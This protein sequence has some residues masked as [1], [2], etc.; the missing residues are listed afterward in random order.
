MPPTWNNQLVVTG[1]PGV[2]T[3]YAND[4][5]I[6]DWTL[7]RNYAFASTDKPSSATSFLANGCRSAPAQ[8]LL[9]W[10]ER[11]SSPSSRPKRCLPS[12]MAPP[13]RRPGRHAAH[14]PADDPAVLSRGLSAP[15]GLG[16]H[17][18]DPAGEP[19]RHMPGIGRPDQHL[20]AAGR[21]DHQALTGHCRSLRRPGSPAAGA[22][23]VRAARVGRCPSRLE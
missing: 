22:T 1:A 11:V 13:R 12:A 15:D 10:H 21:D 17:R 18:Q 2:R 16:D 19:G 7:L 23:W 5:I 20:P 6:S 14:G 8:P 4:N 3:Q 9:A